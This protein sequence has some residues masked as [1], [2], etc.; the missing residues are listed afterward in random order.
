MEEWLRRVLGDG[1]EEYWLDD[2]C[3]LKRNWIA[4][5]GGEL[6]CLWNILLNDSVK[7]LH[8]AQ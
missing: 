5:V 6:M 3:M 8:L 1:W 7:I 4:I 2:D